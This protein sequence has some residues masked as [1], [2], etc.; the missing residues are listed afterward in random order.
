[1][2]I[3]DARER[4][5]YEHELL[6]ARR[7]AEESEQRARALAA[8]LQASFLP[9]ESPTI[10]GLDIAGAYRPAGDGSEVGGDFFDVFDTGRDVWGVVIGDVCGKGAAAA[11]LTSA[12]RYTVRA[13]AARSA[14]PAE[15][16]QVAHAAL[17]RQDPDRFCTAAL[18]F[19]APGPAGW[20]ATV[21]CAGHPLPLLARSDGA[22]RTVGR[23]GSIL[24]MLERHRSF[25][26][27]IELQAGDRVVLYTDGVSEARGDELFGED[28]VVDVLATTTT[29]DAGSTAGAL[30]AAAVDFQSGTTR[31]DIAIVVLR[32]P[33]EKAPDEPSA[34]E[35]RRRR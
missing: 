5:S 3:F 15:V 28:R 7:R 8:T 32:V 9:P 31:D 19:L 22:V 10:P 6:A 35:A 33:D 26:T 20:T 1:M 13:E 11:A 30:L 23:T 16:L 18:L 24:G 34:D 21:A 2:A 17:L 25:D 14:Q 4:R 27:T 12:T 29:S